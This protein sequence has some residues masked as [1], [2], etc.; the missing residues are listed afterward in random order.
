MRPGYRSRR[1]ATYATEVSAFAVEREMCGRVRKVTTAVV[2]ARVAKE[3]E[4]C[5]IRAAED[6]GLVKMLD[7]LT[8]RGGCSQRYKSHKVVC[9]PQAFPPLGS[10]GQY[11]S[12]L[13][14]HHLLA[15][16]S[17]PRAL[18]FQSNVP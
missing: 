15:A 11:Q 12:F 9:V 7:S 14:T 10:G 8:Q 16:F 6:C 4:E 5:P 2:R 3:E 17:L 18:S 13:S 1:K